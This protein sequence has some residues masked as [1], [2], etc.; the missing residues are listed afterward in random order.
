M[1]NHTVKLIWVVIILFTTNVIAEVKTCYFAIA[2]RDPTTDEIAA[3]EST[4]AAG[5]KVPLK[6][7]IF[8]T[9]SLLATF[10]ESTRN[11]L[12]EVVGGGTIGTSEKKAI[13]FNVNNETYSVGEKVPTIEMDNYVSVLFAD[14]N[15]IVT[16]SFIVAPNLEIFMEIKVMKRP[17]DL[18]VVSKTPY[19]ILKLEAMNKGFKLPDRSNTSNPFEKFINSQQIQQQGGTLEFIKDNS[20]GAVFMVPQELTIP[21]KN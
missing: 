19:S 10:I 16:S 17:E 5:E 9:T 4:V 14:L 3:Y 18:I 1:V 8:C 7:R 21:M 20:S 12:P 15:S 6:K 2:D 11:S 13:F